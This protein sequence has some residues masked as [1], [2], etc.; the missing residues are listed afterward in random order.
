MRDELPVEAGRPTSPIFGKREPMTAGSTWAARIA[1]FWP[2]V[3]VVLDVLHAVEARVSEAA[4]ALGVST[5]NLIDFPEHRP[6]GLATG[7][8]LAGSLR[9]ETVALILPD[10]SASEGAFVSQPNNFSWVDR[11]LLAAMARPQGREELD[12]LR[13]QGI[14]L[15]ISLTEDRP[16]RDWINEAGLFALHV[17]VV[18][19]EPPSPE[20]LE[21]CLSAIQRSR[22]PAWA[23]PSIA[24]PAWAAPASSWPAISSPRA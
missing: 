3:G 6:Q 17:P 9:A 18:D 20:Q 16:R 24:A 1:R 19:M 13:Q 8:R 11:P 15:I 12:W 22:R 7:E 4:E 14:Q 21:E 10:P 2:A 23:S 5:G